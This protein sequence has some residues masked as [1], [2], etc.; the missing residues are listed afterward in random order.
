MF[1][2]KK[3]EKFENRINQTNRVIGSA[4]LLWFDWFF[5][6]ASKKKKI[7]SR[8]DRSYQLIR[9]EPNNTNVNKCSTETR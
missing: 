6:K 5:T 8:L 2:E 4:D 3:K 9:S 7:S 1:G